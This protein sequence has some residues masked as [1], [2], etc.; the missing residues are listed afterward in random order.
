MNTLITLSGDKFPTNISR[1]TERPKLKE[2]TFELG[3]SETA[4]VQVPYTGQRRSVAVQNTSTVSATADYSLYVDDDGF[5]IVDD[6]GFLIIDA[7]LT[8][9]LSPGLH[10]FPVVPS[11]LSISFENGSEEGSLTVTVF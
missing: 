10:V 9:E 5:V 6:D 1:S 7:G 3:P 4:T 8:L 11:L 2:Q